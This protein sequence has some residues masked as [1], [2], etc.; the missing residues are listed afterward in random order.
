MTTCSDHSWLPGGLP[1]RTT[2]GRKISGGRAGLKKNYSGRAGPKKNCSGRAGQEKNY[3]G[4]AGPGW[5]IFV[6]A[7]PGGQRK[8]A[9]ASDRTKKTCS[10]FMYFFSWIRCPLWSRVAWGWQNFHG[11]GPGQIKITRAGRAKKKL[12][13]PGRAGQKNN[14]S[15]RAGTGSFF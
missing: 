3:S 6:R 11:P 14:C 2:A 9:R 10:K 5:K 1:E 4:R 12:P 15:G 8:C 7:G 13:G